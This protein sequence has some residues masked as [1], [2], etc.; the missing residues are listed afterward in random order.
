MPSGQNKIL[1]SK[2]GSFG[3]MTHSYVEKAHFTN[4]ISNAELQKFLKMRFLAVTQSWDF[5]PLF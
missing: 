2:E 5:T 4:A 1:I 3:H